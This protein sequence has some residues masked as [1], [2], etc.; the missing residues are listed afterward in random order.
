[1]QI[2]AIESQKHHPE[3]VNIHVDGAYRFALAAELV[4][5]ESLHVGDEISEARIEEL[6]TRDRVWKAR[7]AAL[8]LLSYRPRTAAE[9]RRRLREK[10]YEDDVVE[11][12]VEELVTRGLVDDA[13]FAE[14][15]VRDRVRFRPRGQRRLVQELRTKGVDVETAQAAVEEVM[16]REGTSELELAREAASKWSPRAGEEPLR[17]RRRLFGFLARRGFSGET[18]RQIMEEVLPD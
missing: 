2:T 14:L 10:K 15:F 8:N 1:M 16:E 3:R 13:D 5:A 4:F 11:L 12:T 9:L 17:A 7:E 6:E 18:A